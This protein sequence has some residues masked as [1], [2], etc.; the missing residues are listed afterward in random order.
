MGTYYWLVNHKKK[1]YLNLNG[2]KISEMDNDFDKQMIFTFL[3]DGC[4]RE[5]MELE[6]AGDDTGGWDRCAKYK[7]ITCDI[8]YS[9]FEDGFIPTR[10]QVAF[11]YDKFKEANRLKE[12]GEWIKKF[13]EKDKNSPS[14]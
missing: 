12:F 13:D 10:W 2:A 1:E 7:E 6:F 8:L 11:I 9:M 5:T 4:V 14:G 3:K